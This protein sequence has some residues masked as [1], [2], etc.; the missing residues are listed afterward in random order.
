VRFVCS[1]GG[2]RI[3]GQALTVDGHTEST[4]T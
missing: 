1:P 2:A 3:S 4:R